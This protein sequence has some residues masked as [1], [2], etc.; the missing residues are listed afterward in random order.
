MKI[1]MAPEY[2]FVCV[3]CGHHFFLQHHMEEEVIPVCPNCGSIEVQRLW[4]ALPTFYRGHGWYNTDYPTKSE[5]GEE[6]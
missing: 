2:P 1:I 5:W 4:K 3:D 6:V